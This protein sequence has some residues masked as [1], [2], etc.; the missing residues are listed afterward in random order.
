MYCHFFRHKAS[1]YVKTLWFYI[2]WY[3]QHNFDFLL[4]FFFKRVV[5]FEIAL[6][7]F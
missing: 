5:E 3:T 4:N 6:A 2:I 7:Q 1:L